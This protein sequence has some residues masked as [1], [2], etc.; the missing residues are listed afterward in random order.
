MSLREPR[1]DGASAPYGVAEEGFGA[2]EPTPEEAAERTVDAIWSA[3]AQEIQDALSK[4]TE[5]AHG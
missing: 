2:R 3:H 1:T 4:L 5:T